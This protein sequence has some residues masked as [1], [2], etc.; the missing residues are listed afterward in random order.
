MHSVLLIIASTYYDVKK[1]QA[2]S[3]AGCSHKLLTAYP[4]KRRSARTLPS[5]FVYFCSLD[6]CHV[7]RQGKAAVSMHKVHFTISKT[8]T[9]VIS[10]ASAIEFDIP[11]N[12]SSTAW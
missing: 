7:L 11:T 10:F 2:F 9:A 12:T 1:E 5:F 3:F 8:G 4:A 6:V